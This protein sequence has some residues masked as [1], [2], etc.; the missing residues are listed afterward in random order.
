MRAGSTRV[1]VLGAVVAAVLVPLGTGA[2]PAGAASSASG[3][4]TASM[5]EQIDFCAGQRYCTPSGPVTQ[6]PMTFLGDVPAGPVVADHLTIGG[7]SAVMSGSLVAIPAVSF[8]GTGTAMQSLAGTCSGVFALNGY[9]VAGLVPPIPEPE[10]A[11]DFTCSGVTGTTA[12]SFE[13][14]LQGVQV[15]SEYLATE[16]NPSAASPPPVPLGTGTAAGTSGPASEAFFTLEGTMP[17]LPAGTVALSY[18]NCPISSSSCAFTTSPEVGIGSLDDAQGSCQVSS[19]SVPPVLFDLGCTGTFGSGRAVSFT[20]AVLAA[21]TALDVPD[22]AY[23]A[24]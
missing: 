24:T 6:G 17:F 13:L 2:A 7:W 12:V 22:G 8:T 19:V 20:A 5:S 15:G 14:D 10:F 9:T 18:V 11:E 23:V 4:A 3:V 21:P 16:V 1:R